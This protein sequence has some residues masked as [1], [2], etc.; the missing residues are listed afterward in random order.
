MIPFL[1]RVI[2]EKGRALLRYVSEA[3]GRPAVQ[4]AAHDFTADWPARRRLGGR[5]TVGSR[6][7]YGR[8]LRL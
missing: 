7:N 3:A 4:R 6:F 2:R 8:V 5:N 1:L